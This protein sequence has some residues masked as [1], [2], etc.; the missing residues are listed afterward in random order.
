MNQQT[1]KEWLLYDKATGVFTWL[2]KPSRGRLAGNRAGCKK[3]NYRRIKLL[4]K[5]YYEH[6]LAWMYV[7]G[8]WPDPE[9]DHLNG[10]GT[11]NRWDNLREATSLINKQNRHCARK[12]SSSG[13]IGAMPNKNGWMARIKVNGKNHH[14]GT[15]QTP[16]L[17]SAAYIK[18]KRTLHEGN[19]L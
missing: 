2:K 18:A 13:L 16:E 4:G 12:D 14:L 5:W 3:D 11:D 17:A 15:F 7:T 6:R 9:V 1:V 8:E 19:T 10:H